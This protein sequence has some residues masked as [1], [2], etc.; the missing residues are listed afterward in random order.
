MLRR[1]A[2]PITYIRICIRFAVEPPN[3]AVDDPLSGAYAHYRRRDLVSGEDGPATLTSAPK[4]SHEALSLHPIGRYRKRAG[5]RNT[6]A[7]VAN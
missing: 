6:E 7:Q 2:P 1:Y 3:A 5:R 4:E